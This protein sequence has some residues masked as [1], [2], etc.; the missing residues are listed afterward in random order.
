[1]SSNNPVSKLNELFQPPNHPRY[2]IISDRPEIPP[3]SFELCVQERIFYGEGMSKKEAKRKCAQKAIESL[4][5][6]S[7][8]N[9]MD[10]ANMVDFERMDVEEGKKKLFL[11]LNTI[12]TR[13]VW[14]AKC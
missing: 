11:F 10:E 14:N 5:P 3:F 13:K 12:L 4:I 6:R 7:N 2:R 8:E 1:M 9:R